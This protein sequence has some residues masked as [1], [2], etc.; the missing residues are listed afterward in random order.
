MMPRYLYFSFYGKANSGQLLSDATRQINDFDVS[1]FV[2]GDSAYLLLSS[3]MEPFTQ[4]N[5]D[6][7]QNTIIGF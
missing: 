5:V 3:V 1:K 2:M 7:D 6:T 4:P